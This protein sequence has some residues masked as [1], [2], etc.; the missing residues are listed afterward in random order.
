MSACKDMEALLERYVD[1]ELG[2]TE[3]SRVDNHLSVCEACASKLRLLEREAELLRAALLADETPEGLCENLWDSLQKPAPRFRWMPARWAALAAAAVVLIALLLGLFA[4][5]DHSGRELARITMCAGPLE[6]RRRGEDWQP[7][8]TY[9]MLRH[10]D[11]VRCRGSRAGTLVVDVDSRF[12]LDAGTALVFV[13]DTVEGG[14]TVEMECGRLHARLLGLGEPL[15]IQT[16]VADVVVTVEE[17]E[18]ADPTELELA[19][20]GVPER[21][22]FLDRIHLLPAAYA[23]PEG[24]Q[25][26]VRVFEGFVLVVSPTDLAT[27][28]DSGER[29]V[30]GLHG[31]PP[32]PA[33][34]DTSASSAWWPDGLRVAAGRSAAADPFDEFVPARRPALPSEPE[35]I[36]PAPE[37]PGPRDTDSTAPPPH[38]EPA[39]VP[40]APTRLVA[41]PDIEGILLSWEPVD[42]RKR[43]VVEYGIYRRA[44]GDTEL[45]LIG[46]FPVVGSDVRK[47]EFHDAG[48]AI[49]AKYQYA[50]AAAVRDED[51]GALVEGKLSDV[52]TVSPLD[53]R[54]RYTGGD[55]EG[56]A[57]IVV[58]KLHDGALRRQTFMVRKQNA[59]AGETGEIGGV[60]QVVVEPIEGVRHRAEIDFSTGYRLVDIITQVERENGVPKERPAVVIENERSTPKTLVQHTVG[61]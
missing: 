55:G 24:P 52:V 41:A 51:S 43:P 42:Y 59:A 37:P 21:L 33:A 26:E 7:L 40:S 6:V 47:Y 8:A 17:S 36:P 1:G 14:F 45:A 35:V 13:E 48:L 39:D 56:L 49:G 60:R 22:G 3:T 19:L 44:P 12:D 32:Q 30:V 46:R 58:E 23:A 38:P 25:L 28:V 4:P 57:I 20:T 29:V 16:P 10:G 18:I 2:P 53:F 54:L 34:F 15:T 5:G 31:P 9:T 27:A 11:R 50:V 61:P